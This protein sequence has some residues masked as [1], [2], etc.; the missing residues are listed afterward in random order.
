MYTT[1]VKEKLANIKKI[2]KLSDFNRRNIKSDLFIWNNKLFET[3][4][5]EI[6]LQT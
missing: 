5:L 3:L 6:I 4:Y 1:S 2:I